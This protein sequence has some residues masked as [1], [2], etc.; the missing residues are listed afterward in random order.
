M[1]VVCVCIP[2]CAEVRGQQWVIFFHCSRV[3]VCVCV[4]VCVRARARAL[5]GMTA[6][7]VYSTDRIQR[8][9]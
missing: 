1:C 3:C 9:L 7:L 5:A 2:A 4:C 6:P 8:G